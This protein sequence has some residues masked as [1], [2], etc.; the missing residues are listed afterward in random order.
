MNMCVRHLQTGD[1]LTG[2][3]IYA[4]VQE[5]SL[6]EHRM[7][8]PPGARGNVTYIAPAGEYSL[9]DKVIEVEFGGVK[10]VCIA[11]QHCDADVILQHCKVQLG[12]KAS[13]QESKKCVACGNKTYHSNISHNDNDW[14]TTMTRTVIIVTYI[15]RHVSMHESTHEQV[16]VCMPFLRMR[17]LMPQ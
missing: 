5:N 11:L 4:T 2:G 17:E 13:S 16:Y 6:I 1:R 15:N 12:G 3:D 8:L 10:K 7:M 9:E 14:T